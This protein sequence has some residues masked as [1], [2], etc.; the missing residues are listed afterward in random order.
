MRPTYDITCYENMPADPV[1]DFIDAPLDLEEQ[2][3]ALY[4]AADED[5]CRDCGESHGQHTEACM[6]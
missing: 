6:P 5:Q 3:D 4:A 1:T 2:L